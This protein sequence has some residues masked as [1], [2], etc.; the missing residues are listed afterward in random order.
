MIIGLL[1]A[2]ASQFVYRKFVER[3]P[4][5]NVLV[6]FA[7]QGVAGGLGALGTGCFA[8]SSVGGYN[9]HGDEIGGLLTGNSDQVVI[10]ATAM[11]CV[12]ALAFVATYGLSRCVDLVSG[13]RRIQ[14]QTS[15]SGLT[16]N[17]TGIGPVA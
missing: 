1:S 11:A 3:A 15:E 5:R 10:Q 16:P 4:N 8:A 14:D 9:R 17:G 6:P 12:A 7:L 13:F 2:V